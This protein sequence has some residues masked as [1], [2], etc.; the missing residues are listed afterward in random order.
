MRRFFGAT[1]VDLSHLPPCFPHVSLPYCHAADR[2]HHR[3][4]GVPMRKLVLFSVLLAFL[5]ISSFV[6]GGWLDPQVAKPP[7]AKKVAKTTTLH[8]D[9]RVDYYQWLCDKTDKEVIAYLNAENAYTA[10]VMKPTEALQET[11]YTEM[12]GRI[13]QTDL[14]VPYRLGHYFY[15]TRTVQ[16]KQYNI[17]CRKRAKPLTPNPS[18]PR[19]EG[20]L[21]AAEE[22]II[23]DLNEQAKGQ[24]FLMLG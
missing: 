22:E 24:K 9:T 14:S 1:I 16:G 17:H 12:L 3:L 7:V 21:D 10:A 4:K 8:G 23:L 11:L 20:N 15:Y 5:V 18:P 6:A 2:S 13:K 19:G